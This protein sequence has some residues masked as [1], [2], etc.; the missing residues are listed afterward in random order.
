MQIR[1]AVDVDHGAL[2]GNSN[3][4]LHDFVITLPCTLSREQ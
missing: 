1:F 3:P 2:L 4:N